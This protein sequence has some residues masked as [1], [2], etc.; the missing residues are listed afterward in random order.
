MKIAHVQHPF[1]PNMG[2]QENHLPK[3]QRKLGHDVV[4]L[5]S[6]YLPSW[7][8]KKGEKISAGRYEVNGINL[9]RHNTFLKLRSIGQPILSGLNSSLDEFQPD[10]IHA[11]GLLSLSTLQA[12][13]YAKRNKIPLFV[14]SHIDNGNLNIDNIPKVLGYKFFKNYVIHRVIK[15]A[16]FIMPVNSKAKQFIQEELSVPEDKIQMLPLGVDPDVFSPDRGTDRIRQK[17]K[18]TQDSILIIS[19]GNLNESKDLDI[20]LD[21]FS[22]YSDYGD[23]DTVL[24]LLGNWD[25][26]YRVEIEDKIEELIQEDN[27]YLLGKVTNE[28][29]AHYYN[30]ADFG[31]WPGKLGI[32][33]LE[34]I[35]CGLPVI[36]SD[37]LATEHLIKN[38]NGLSF[39]R[40]NVEA[41]CCQIEK[42]AENPEVRS[43]HSTAARQYA[44]YDLAWSE[45]AKQ[46]I[47]L[48]KKNN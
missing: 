48:Y 47:E 44:K 35:G 12:Y 7:A 18:I 30:A 3:E 26:D 19:A 46:S 11:H 45:I 25:N 41:L 6:D 43:K 42:Y 10:I 16:T 13:R 28:N 33:I 38:N 9:I 5:T 29:L 2:Y 40:G 32:T 20:L 27:V 31:V 17:F 14:D 34:A 4:I 24:L 36:V 1:I 22:L 8:E 39:P 21:S 15:Y 23:Q 37:S